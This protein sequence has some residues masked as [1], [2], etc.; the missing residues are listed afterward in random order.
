M[1]KQWFKVVMKTLALLMPFYIIYYW[2]LHDQS[3]K[4]FERSLWRFTMLGFCIYLV[5]AILYL[6]L[7]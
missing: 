5:A 6:K 4:P 1:R 2:G 3:E 7:R